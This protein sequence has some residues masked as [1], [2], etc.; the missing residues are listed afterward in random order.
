MGAVGDAFELALTAHAGQTDKAGLA[1]I[2]HVARV[3]AGVQGDEA[4]IVALLHDVIEDAGVAAED[5]SD[6]FGHRIAAAV[7]ALT[8]HKGESPAGYYARVAAD[9]LARTV[10]L[11]D[12]AD[13]SHPARLAMLDPVTRTR[14]QAKYAAARLALAAP[15]P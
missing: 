6:R 7:A 3:A 11:A 14:L 8:R 12:I 4:R 2:G 13:N 1:Y 9:P 5:L 10:K 15:E